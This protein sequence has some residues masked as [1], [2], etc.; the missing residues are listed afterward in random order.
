M[1]RKNLARRLLTLKV[2]CEEAKFTVESAA[3]YEVDR[4]WCSSVS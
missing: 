1:V 2:G 4:R 3:R